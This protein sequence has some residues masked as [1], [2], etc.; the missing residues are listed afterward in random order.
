[1]GCPAALA[2]LAGRLVLLVKLRHTSAI[3]MA[4]NKNL[5]P[6]ATLT[7]STNPLVEDRLERIVSTGYYGKNAAEAAERLIAQALS[8]LEKQGD[9]PA[10]QSERR[11]HRQP[12]RAEV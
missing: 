7:I 6:T 10:R 2:A 11:P 1:M 5:L 9:I 4:T 8:T 3:T 12:S